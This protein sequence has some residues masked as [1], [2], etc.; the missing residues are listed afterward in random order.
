MDCLILPLHPKDIQLLIAIIGNVMHNPKDEKYRNIN[1]KRLKTKFKEPKICINL[2]YVAGFSVIKLDSKRLV[3]NIKQSHQLM[4][5]YQELL[6]MQSEL[7]YHYSI[8]SQ[9]NSFASKYLVNSYN[10]HTQTEMMPC[11]LNDCLLLVEKIGSVL[12]HY[13]IYIKENYSS[14]QVNKTKAN[15]IETCV[16]S[17]MSNNYQM[18]DLL[19]DHNHLLLYHSDELEHIYEIL[20]AIVYDGN[21]CNF[22]QCLQL[23]RNHRDRSNISKNSLYHTEDNIV[24]EQLLDRI[25]SFYF[26]TFDIG[27]KLTQKEKILVLENDT[28][29]KYE[30]G[31][32]KNMVALKMCNLLT[33]K[34]RYYRNVDGLQRLKNSPNNKFITTNGNMNNLCNNYSFGYR[35]YYWKHYKNSFGVNDEA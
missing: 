10:L 12:K 13:S 27:Y 26:H 25:H 20:C 16:F 6:S 30:S 21:S 2:L 29:A 22:T 18:V 8:N 31:M 9:K 24:T 19:N 7:S 14:K 33:I 11:K 4:S 23:R 1:V 35:F 28:E 15:D 5:I 17:A 32:D 3:Y 34:Q